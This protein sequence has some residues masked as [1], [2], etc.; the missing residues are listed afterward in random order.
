MTCRCTSSYQITSKCI[1]CVFELLSQFFD[2]QNDAD[3]HLV[4]YNK[5][6]GLLMVQRVERPICIITQNFVEIGQTFA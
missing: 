2:F 4:G 3:D 5:H 1:S 6:L